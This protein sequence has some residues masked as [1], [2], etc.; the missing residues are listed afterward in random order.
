MQKKGSKMGSS[1]EVDQ[2]VYS[3]ISGVKRKSI[4]ESP[5]ASSHASDKG[6][7]LSPDLMED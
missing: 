2:N 4:P 6:F 7:H 5:Q 1:L 3:G